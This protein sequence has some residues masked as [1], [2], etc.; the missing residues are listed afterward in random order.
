MNEAMWDMFKTI[1]VALISSGSVTT[2]IT[3]YFSKH[4]KVNEL[5]NRLE[6]IT[7]VINRQGEA[8][9]ALLHSNMELLNVLHDKGTINGESQHLR[10]EFAHYMYDSQAKGFKVKEKKKA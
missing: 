3:R 8:V 7:K 1:I 9:Q 10:D 4:N 2:L 6:D 5:E